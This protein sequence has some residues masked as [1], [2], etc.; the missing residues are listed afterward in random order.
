MLKLFPL[1][2]LVALILLIITLPTGCDKG[3]TITYENRTSSTVWIEVDIVDHEF[4][5]WHEPTEKI[6]DEGPILP[7]ESESFVYFGIP[8]ERD[9][10]EHVGKYVISAIVKEEPYFPGT[11]IYQRIFTWSELHDMD[12]N[13]IIK[14]NIDN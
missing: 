12:W 1:K 3:P 2:V 6:T 10:G 5:G 14:E 8:Y 11:V 4:T 7:G 13:V 9:L